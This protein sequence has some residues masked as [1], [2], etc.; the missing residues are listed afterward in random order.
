[1]VLDPAKNES[2]EILKKVR[3][4]EIKT[5]RLVAELFSGEY[6]S[7]FKGQGMEFA[8][9]REYSPGDDIR[10]IDWNVTA[11]MG[12]PFVKRFTEERQLNVLLMVDL[13]GSGNFGSQNQFKTEVAAELAAVLAFSAIRNNDRI[14]LLT[15]TDC[16]E[17][18]LPPKK[19]SQ[20]GMQ[21]IREILYGRAQG[22]KTNL[23]LALEHIMKITRRRCVIF[24]I[25]D[26]MD[27][28]FE[29]ALRLVSK[30][31]DL[32]AFEV[33]DALELGIPSSGLMMFED[34]ETG[35]ECLVDAGNRRFREAYQRGQVSRREAL[36]KLFKACG[37]DHVPIATNASYTQALNKLF[38]NR[39]RR[40]S[41]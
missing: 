10:S 26:F 3:R 30:K 9:V 39:K 8:E 13:S 32:I 5:R 35:E 12:H 2:F 36:E 31:H 38:K 6:H 33:H 37:I 4:L 11:K 21:I 16:I 20:Y 40:V 17:K 29:K 23:T 18:Y 19:Q 25:S 27:R 15:F 22:K 41:R 7:V 34:P 1:M 14:G 24:L 28:G